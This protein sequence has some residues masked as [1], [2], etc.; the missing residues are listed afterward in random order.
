[1]NATPAMPLFS[2]TWVAQICKFGFH[3]FANAMRLSR[4]IDKRAE[5]WMESHEVDFF[6]Y[7]IEAAVNK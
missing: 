7:F 1:V 5:R 6:A 4:W 2:K 3:Y